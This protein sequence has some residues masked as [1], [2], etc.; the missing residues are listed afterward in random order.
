MERIL[1]K[2][3]TTGDNDE[4]D[5]VGRRQ[6]GARDKTDHGPAPVPPQ[7][8]VFHVGPSGLRR[9]TRKKR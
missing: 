5:N 3:H 6:I 1:R 8:Q 9:K 7:W 4:E 2:E